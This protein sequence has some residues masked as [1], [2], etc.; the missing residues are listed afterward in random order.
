M[1]GVQQ[2]GG[3]MNAV[4]DNPIVGPLSG[5]RIVDSTSIQMGPYATM[6][7]ADLGADVIKIE[8]PGGDSSRQTSPYVHKGMGH[9]F[10]NSNRNKRSVALD[11]KHPEG[12]AAL[13]EIAKR[14]DVF[15]HNVRPQAMERLK[16]G[17]EAFKAVNP[18]II[19]V[20]AVGFGAK[21]R[22]GGSPALDDLIQGMACIPALYQ[23]AT[24]HE[25]R[26][27]P[28]AFADRSSAL[29][30]ALA[31]LSGVVSRNSTGR[32]QK[33]DVPM[34][35]NLVHTIFGE[36]LEG[37]TFIP[38]RG[39]MGHPR[40]VSLERRP[41]RTKDGF[42][43]TLIYNDKQWGNFFKIINEPGKFQS[44][45]RFS[46]MEN[47]IKNIDSIYQFLSDVIE[48]Q[49]TEY[50]IKHFVEHEIPI[51]KMHSLEDTLHDPHLS[52]VNF[53]ASA[54]HPTEGTIR[55]MYY[56]TAF[57][58]TPLTPRRH[59]PRL[60]EHTFE[61]LAEYG[62]TSDK[63]KELVKQGIAVVPPA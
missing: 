53:F 54:K 1:K 44:D 8:S 6:I 35:E 48:T 29:H 11:L 50:W 34:F 3:N 15:V 14:G 57:S 51:A 18:K 28:T 33:I 59:A 52:D 40:T 42:I 22:Y 56:Q 32:G 41:Y 12:R 16:L 2:C 45:H 39:A 17:Y 21:G 43:C 9:T 36:H 19:Y 49:T 30:V 46:T 62:Y 7:L 38:P 23:Q 31:I 10:L 4:T 13:L 37:E 58:E 27:V 25:P 20:A 26:Y 5:I 47:R 63:I 61:V 55:E 60:G 24:G